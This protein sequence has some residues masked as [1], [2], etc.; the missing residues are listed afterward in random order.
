MKPC[1]ISVTGVIQI[2]RCSSFSSA[3]VSILASEM[4]QMMKT[5][6]EENEEVRKWVKMMYVMREASLHRA[7][8]EGG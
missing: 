5:A 2:S 8:Q 1:G 4:P 7:Q 6:A 3:L